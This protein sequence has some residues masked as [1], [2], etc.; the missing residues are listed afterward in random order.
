M[1]MEMETGNDHQNME[2]VAKQSKQATAELEFNIVQ[3]E[4]I[5][6]LYTILE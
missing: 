2:M 5:W 4:Y 3:S 6:K 1:E